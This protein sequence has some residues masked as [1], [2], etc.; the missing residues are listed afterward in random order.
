MIAF[1]RIFLLASFTESFFKALDFFWYF[2]HWDRP[3]SL[4]IHLLIF[5]F[6]YYIYGSDFTTCFVV[7]FKSFSILA[8]VLGG[9][10][11]YS[12]KHWYLGI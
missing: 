3:D 12:I 10:I 6:Y 7:R 9:I 4:V 11:Q 8:A 1:A 5:G 2:K